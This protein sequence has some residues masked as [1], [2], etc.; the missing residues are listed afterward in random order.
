M[1]KLEDIEK[2]VAELSEEERKNLR[3]FLD[4]LDWQAWDEQIANDGRAGRLDAIEARA[5]ADY[6]A[7]RIRKP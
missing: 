5:R 6:K 7:G 4:E 3:A 1:T 2:A